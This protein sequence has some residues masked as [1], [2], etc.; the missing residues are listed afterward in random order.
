MCNSLFIA[1]AILF[2]LGF[3]FFYEEY[4]ILNNIIKILDNDCYYKKVMKIHHE[5]QKENDNKKEVGGAD[6]KL[7]VNVDTDPGLRSNE[8][9]IKE[10]N[11][12]LNKP[13][14]TLAQKPS[15]N[16]PNQVVKRSTL[17]SVRK[18]RVKPS[19]SSSLN[20]NSGNIEKID[21]EQEEIILNNNK[22]RQDNPNLM[23][24]NQINPELKIKP[25]FEN[26]PVKIYEA[27]QSKQ[28]RQTK[29]VEESA[30]T[31]EVY[32]NNYM[33]G[34]FI[35]DRNI[36]KQNPARLKIRFPEN[37][38]P[39]ERLEFTLNKFSIKDFNR[40]SEED[41]IIYDKRTGAE[42]FCDLLKSDHCIL[43]LFFVKSLMHPLVFRFIHL[44]LSLGLLLLFNALAFVDDYINV[45][46]TY[47]K[48][49]VSFIHLES[50]P[51]HNPKRNRK[52]SHCKP[53]IQYHDHLDRLDNIR[54]KTHRG[55][56]QCVP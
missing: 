37:A 25:T 4:Y 38:K 46:A 45:R 35:C 6:I 50:F 42:Y 48:N 36:R 5:I 34:K 18:V 40:L 17:L 23:T 27:M 30:N 55:G 33:E 54:S 12:I 20:L 52:E 28:S 14:I 43:N 44:F 26:N 11:L 3:S 32:I 51:L 56:I 19:I 22:Q 10:N 16:S 24:G 21:I 47:N 1:I 41:K 49:I 29:M 15:L 9:F 53:G 13:K 31:K 7:S 39:E 2:S 8:S